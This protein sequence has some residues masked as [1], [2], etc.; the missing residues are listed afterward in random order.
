M[1]FGIVTIVFSDESL[2]ISLK[3]C[4]SARLLVL[5]LRLKNIAVRCLRYS[6]LWIIYLT[7]RWRHVIMLPPELRRLIP[8]VWSGSNENVPPNASQF[9][10]ARC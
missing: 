4:E 10:R 3:S 1:N 6:D 9:S 8:L 2:V 5:E 7:S